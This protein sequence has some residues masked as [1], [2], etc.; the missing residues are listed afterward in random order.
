[1]TDAEAAAIEELINVVMEVLT[2]VAYV[3]GAIICLLGFIFVVGGL[4]CLGEWAR[5]Y[6]RDVDISPQYTPEGGYKGHRE[7]GYTYESAFRKKKRRKEVNRRRRQ[8]R[9][10]RGNR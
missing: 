2:Y 10:N 5:C 6:W 7:E 8:S 3:G 1:M 9:K 4:A